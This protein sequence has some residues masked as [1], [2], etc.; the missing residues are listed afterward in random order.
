MPDFDRGGHLVTWW[1]WAEEQY[2]RRDKYGVPHGHWQCGALD[3]YECQE[4]A[5][6]IRGLGKIAG[7]YAASL[8][9]PIYS[10]YWGRSGERDFNFRHQPP[11]RG[12]KHNTARKK[13]FG[14][15][16]LLNIAGSQEVYVVEESGRMTLPDRVR[17]NGSHFPS[18]PCG[19]RVVLL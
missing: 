15:F 10:S 19:G 2:T 13:D 6:A 17:Q 12:K 5:L 4:A 9:I 8:V 14:P 1:I 16:L 11:Q 7:V 3:P 18:S